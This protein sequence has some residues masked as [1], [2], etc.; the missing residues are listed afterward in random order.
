VALSDYLNADYLVA[1]D[2]EE[3]KDEEKGIKIPPPISAAPEPTEDV[4]EEPTGL[5]KYLDRLT[6]VDYD[7]DE[8]AIDLEEISTTRKLAYGAAQETTIGGNIMRYAEALMDSSVEDESFSESLANIEDQRQK[9]IFRRFSE[10]RGL[11]E[12]EEDA[13]IL[14]G[15]IGTAIADPI[16][17]LIPWTKVAKAGKIASIATAGGV[18]A[19]DAALREKMIYGEINPISV[20]AATVFGGTAGAISAKL[21]GKLSREAREEVLSAIDDVKPTKLD[22]DLEDAVPITAKEATTI[23]DSAKRVV[24]ESVTEEIQN[25]ASF[26]S[27][28][29]RINDIDTLIDDFKGQKRKARGKSAKAEIQKKISLLQGARRKERGKVL[30]ETLKM[31][32]LVKENSLKVAEDLSERGELTRGILKTLVFEPTRPIMGA[33]G[34]FAASGVLGDE[35]DDALTIG[36]MVA[37]A[38][39]GN[40][41]TLLKRSKLTDFD[42]DGAMQV[43][44]EVAGKFLH[45]EAK[46]ATAGTTA[47]RMDAMGG[48]AKAIGR[49]MFGTVGGPH[50]GLED[51]I[52][53]H[54][55]EYVN[56]TRAI[57]GESFND[58][59]VERAVGERLR[60][61][62]EPR[63]IKVG[64]K[65]LDGSFE[66]GLTAEQVAE[67]RRIIPLMR[68]HQ[69][70]IKTGMDES[71]VVFKDLDNY[72]MAQLWD[73][74]AI[75]KNEE[76]FLEAL[77]EAV[78]KQ[79]ENF[80]KEIGGLEADLV[81]LRKAKKSAGVTPEEIGAIEDQIK[82]LK[83]K[84]RLTAE[85]FS[86]AL[87]G[88]K[89]LK[90][91]EA[92]AA[93]H[94]SMFD[95]D[96]TFRPLAKHFEWERQLADTEA[97]KI[98][99][100]AG[101]LNMNAREVVETY[102][103]KSIKIMDFSRKFGADGELITEALKDVTKAFKGANLER[104]EQ[105]YRR[106][107][108][109]AVDGFW[110][111]YQKGH[112]VDERATTGVALFT[113]LANMS[114]LTRVSITS[115]GDI[116]QPF[117]NS[118]FGATARA[119][120]RKADPNKISFHKQ[121]N[122]R[123]NDGFE[124]EITAMMIK[125]GDPLNMR[126]RQIANMNR[127]FFKAVGLQHLTNAARDFAFDTGVN[128]AFKLATKGKLTKGNRSE[129]DQ[130]G[131]YI[132]DLDVLKKY[133]TVQEAFDAGDARNILDRA[134]LRSANRDAIVPSVGNRLLFAQS[135]NP[136]MRSLGQFASWAQAKTS[137]TNAL[138]SRVDSGDAA[139]ALRMLGLTTVYGGV[140]Q[141][142][143]WAK[144]TYDDEKGKIDDFISVK[145]LKKALELSGNWMPWH[146]DK[147]VRAMQS[148]NYGSGVVESSVPAVSFIGEVAERGSGI[149]RNIGQGDIEGAGSHTMRA[150]PILKDI[151]GW[152][153]RL[154]EAAGYDI[155]FED[156]P[157]DREERDWRLGRAIGGVVED[158]PRVPKEPD[159]R[160]DK[161]TGR[162]YN[163]QA[164]GA[165]IDAEDP[166]RRLGFVG[167]GVIDNPLR[168]LGFGAGGKVYNALRR[169]KAEGG[170]N[171]RIVGETENEEFYLTNYDTGSVRKEEADEEEEERWKETEWYDRATDPKEGFLEDEEGRHTLLTASSALD[172]KEILYPTIRKI[173][174]QL[175]RLSDK[176]ARRKAIEKG[177]YITFDT[178]DEAT[179]ASM[180]ISDSI[181]PKRQFRQFIGHLKEREGDREDVY[182][183]TEGHLTV[184]AGHKLTAAEKKKYKLGDVVDSETLDRFLRDDS[185]KAWNAAEK[186]AQKLGVDDPDFMI[187]LASVNFQLGTSWNKEHKETWKKLGR[188]NWEE[189]ALEAADSKWF[190]QTPT[191]VEDFQEAI[192]GLIGSGATLE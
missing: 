186:Q 47:T 95:S 17:W 24:P 35:D 73:F 158:V 108:V 139:L 81:V 77:T 42:K 48:W 90:Q 79:K 170:L 141:M 56:Q 30:L 63:H 185:I 167:G 60:R 50:Q 70:I 75:A 169:R 31:D 116:I 174:G 118:G 74:E 102:G 18:A 49:M 172:G 27:R 176:E 86:D 131:L 20:G 46:I 137:Q 192:R 84:S 114:F 107:I 88:R 98:M 120:I 101:F 161:L 9:D 162:P 12:T 78:K 157:P 59:Q 87:H 65:G 178:P 173:D 36:M 156:T 163:E 160:I 184:G 122:F 126:H 82:V 80:S 97:S 125:G 4:A 52:S 181:D 45:R 43:V 3:E 149:G 109:N 53:R 110:G 189:A 34:G 104:F 26:N 22:I 58:I 165:F 132:E 140:G 68:R 40:W 123:Y 85:G 94:T 5:S 138:A 190:D 177:D 2:D 38:G 21:A 41:A 136:F 92:Q 111:L 55:R 128:R 10:F 164:G 54:T 29:K 152:I 62:V 61:F 155:R 171:K 91:R 187:A 154:G 76:G 144:P 124:K 6:V 159:E 183:D 44:N 143:E 11:A 32:R 8:E 112:K 66:K 33:V 142:R 151:S 69:K 134:G 105:Q 179:E 166:L 103:E 121:A 71:G 130:L 14:A 129:L 72:G 133:K 83:R 150:I 145:G 39:L 127:K 168:R 25:T 191:R 180:T 153:G 64:Y 117:Q 146:I 147:A 89:S 93:F 96:G 115:L 100:K 119:L 106:Q 148:W 7:E 182:E 67:V 1:V 57:F 135:N 37:G 51:Q 13:A 28:Y 23:Q 188:G 113:A 99:A 16:T 15:R 175:K 19:G